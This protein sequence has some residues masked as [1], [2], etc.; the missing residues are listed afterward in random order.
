MHRLGKRAEDDSHLCQLALESRRYRNAV[1]NGIDGHAGKLFLLLQRNTELLI[2]F[3]QLRIHFFET[4]GPIVFRLGRRIVADRLIIDGRIMNV[5]PL[6][7]R[8][9]FLQFRPVAIRFE[10]PIEHELGLLLFR[11]NQTNDV[12]IQTGRYGIRLDVGDEAVLVLTLGEIFDGMGRGFHFCVFLSP[13]K[14]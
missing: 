7:L 8:L 4:L 10:P 2:H 12:F 11:R 9:R 14:P 13:T 3:E 1:E 6:G 5:G